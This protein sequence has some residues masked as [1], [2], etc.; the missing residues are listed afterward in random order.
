M[1]QD[2]YYAALA[3]SD[4]AAE[5]TPFVTFMLG[6]LLAAMEEALQVKD[7]GDHPSD[8]V[9]DPVREQ[10]S[11]LVADQVREQVGDQ[12]G[13]RIGRLLAVFRG[14]EALTIGEIM[15][16]LGLQHRPTIRKNYLRPALAGGWI[17]MTQ[18]DS[19]SSPTQRY[20]LTPKARPS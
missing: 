10:A 14:H 7:A 20:R 15:Q 1:T 17:V 3:A 13:A 11:D 2:A 9:R 5:S 6:T 18:P 16:R 4:R 19:P 12:A 8:P